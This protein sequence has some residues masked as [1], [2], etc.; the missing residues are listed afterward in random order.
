M[1]R[2]GVDGND[3]NDACVF[4]AEGAAR[5]EAPLGLPA[6]MQPMGIGSLGL[7]SGSAAAQ[8]HDLGHSIS[9]SELVPS[10]VRED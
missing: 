5:A 7:N 3:G 1:W 4:P 2:Q 10:C 9:Y 8:P 6:V